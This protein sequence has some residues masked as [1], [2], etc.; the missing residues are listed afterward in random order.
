MTPDQALREAALA[1]RTNQFQVSRHVLEERMPERGASRRDLA[2]A[3]QS[4]TSA[5]HQER[6][7]W[8][9]DGGRDD[10]GDLLTL[11][12]AFEDGV[13]IVTLF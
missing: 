1:G 3:L 12:V 9:I 13:L 2:L 10:A 6:S 11:I 8:R 4:A 7:K 5:H